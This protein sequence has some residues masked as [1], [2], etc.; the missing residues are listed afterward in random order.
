MREVSVVTYRFHTECLSSENRESFIN[1][2]LI[3]AE[4]IT[5]YNVPN[6]LTFFASTTKMVKQTRVKIHSVFIFAYQK[7]SVLKINGRKIAKSPEIQKKLT[8]NNNNVC[9]QLLQPLDLAEIQDC[10]GFQRQAV[11]WSFLARILSHPGGTGSWNFSTFLRL[12]ERCDIRP[13]SIF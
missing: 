10:C 4:H 3:P 2:T 12:D 13:L 9:L 5:T 1:P 6:N 11:D 8:A 7:S